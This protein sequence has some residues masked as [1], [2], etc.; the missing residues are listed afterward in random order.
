MKKQGCYYCDRDEGFRELLFEICDLKASKIFLCKDQTLPGRC[1]IMFKEHYEEIYEIP[2]KERDL[3]MD[4][5]CALA[6]TIKEIFKADKINYGIYGDTCRHVHYT[7]CPKYEGK[8]GW[9]TTFVM[10]PD[11]EERVYLTDEEYEERK[12][13][14]KKTVRKKLGL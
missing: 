11:P 12:A 10:F 7:I 5:V 6:E 3:Y 1:T 4:D 13:L 8:L 14:I 9:G 2:K